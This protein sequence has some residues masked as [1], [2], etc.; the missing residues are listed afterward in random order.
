MIVNY[1]GE[2]FP[3]QMEDLHKNHSKTMTEYQVMVMAMSGLND[4][5][6]PGLEGKI[7]YMVFGIWLSK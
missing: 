6:W 3:R 2:Y 4:W 5:Q 1:K 7:W